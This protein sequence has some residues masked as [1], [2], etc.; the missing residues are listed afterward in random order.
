MYG[1]EDGGKWTKR[2]DPVAASRMAFDFAEASWDDDAFNNE[3]DRENAMPCQ[4]K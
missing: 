2:A 1:G 4:G 3:H